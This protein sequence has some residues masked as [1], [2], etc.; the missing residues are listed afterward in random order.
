MNDC[1]GE[2]SSDVTHGVWCVAA[3]VRRIVKLDPEVKNVAKDAALLIAKAAVGPSFHFSV[4]LDICGCLHSWVR[5]TAVRV[6][7]SR[8]CVW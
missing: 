1:E 6:D 2:T 3:S 4:C 8:H 7:F 5:T